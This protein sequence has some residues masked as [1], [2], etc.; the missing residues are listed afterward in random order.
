M[1]DPSVTAAEE[2]IV[3]D[4]LRNGWYGKDAYKYTELFEQEF[5]KYHGWTYALMTPNCHS[6]MH[7]LL[8][9]L[10]ISEGD[11]VIVPNVPG[12]VLRL[13]FRTK[14]VKLFLRILIP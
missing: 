14:G 13:P 8:K 4:A 7:L 2:Q 1:A 6:A 10:G 12:L 3:L 5:S 11:E 9:E